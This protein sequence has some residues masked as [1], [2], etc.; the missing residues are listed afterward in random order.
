[1]DSP[2]VAGRIRIV[3][4]DCHS[5]SF[6]KET[7]RLFDSQKLSGGRQGA[8][9]MKL[10]NIASLDPAI[11][12]TGLTGLKGRLPLYDRSM[13]A[14]MQSDWESFAVE[15]QQAITAIATSNGL[16]ESTTRERGN[17]PRWRRPYCADYGSYRPKL[18]PVGSDERLQWAVL[19]HWSCFAFVACG[20]SHRSLA[21]RQK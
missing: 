11:T 2:T 12:S 10:T 6:I 5:G 4:V 9:A 20:Q 16:D 21:S 7:L 8:L 19:H 3:I 1:M 14:E 18:L 13:W 17:I 15:S